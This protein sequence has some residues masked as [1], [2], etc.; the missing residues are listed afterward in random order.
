MRSEASNYQA[1]PRAIYAKRCHLGGACRIGHGVEDLCSYLGMRESWK[2]REQW[3]GV[4]GR[5]A[6]G[7]PAPQRFAGGVEAQPPLL[8]L[9]LR[10]TVDRDWAGA[11][12]A[13][14]GWEAEDKSYRYR[15][16]ERGRLA[17]PIPMLAS[18]FRVDQHGPAGADTSS[19]DVCACVCGQEQARSRRADEGAEE[20][21]WAA[22][23]GV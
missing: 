7:F 9:G 17:D 10:H 4:A 5:G 3:K 22:E 23:G 15:T 20:W 19:G 16:I 18:W 14:I 2:H 12:S 13:A 8:H 6:S 21:P 11:M 1:I